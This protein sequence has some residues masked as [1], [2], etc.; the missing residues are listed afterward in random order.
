MNQ[1]SKHNQWQRERQRERVSRT[2][3][4]NL[5]LLLSSGSQR[6]G[7]GHGGASMDTTVV[8]VVL[9]ARHRG[10]AGT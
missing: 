10:G 4:T 1:I 5:E 8:E 6:C 3:A 7:G 2:P 9:Q